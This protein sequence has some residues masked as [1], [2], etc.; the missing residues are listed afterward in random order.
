MVQNGNIKHRQHQDRLLNLDKV[1][2]DKEN[3][4]I[5]IVE[6]EKACDAAQKLFPSSIV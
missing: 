2:A 6:G 1:L 4:T 3:K 5:L